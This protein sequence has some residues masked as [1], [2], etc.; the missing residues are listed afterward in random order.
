MT[1]WIC[2]FSSSELSGNFI[3]S[4]WILIFVSCNCT[5][6]SSSWICACWLWF[7]LR[8]SSLSSSSSACF[9][10]ASPLA[11][12]ECTSLHRGQAGDWSMYK[13]LESMHG[14]ASSRNSPCG[15]H[16]CPETFHQACLIMFVC[17]C[18]RVSVGVPACLSPLKAALLTC[19]FSQN[20]KHVKVT[21]ANLHSAF[22]CTSCHARSLSIAEC[23]KL[24]NC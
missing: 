3:S 10:S 8:G 24:H 4:S 9:R 6:L 22:E 20:Q 7:T 18:V 5:F 15:S 21:V 14:N 11:A 12:S 16:F 2:V 1:S 17:V 19:T 23:C 13:K